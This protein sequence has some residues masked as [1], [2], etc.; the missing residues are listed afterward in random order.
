M[1][2][3]LEPASIATLKGPTL[4]LWDSIYTS[5][6]SEAFRISVFE[7]LMPGLAKRFKLAGIEIPTA[8]KATLIARLCWDRDS[9]HL[10]PH[11]DKISK[12]TT[13]QIYLPRDSQQE[14]IGTSLF[15]ERGG[16]F[17]EVKKFPF[18]PNSGYAFVVQRDGD[19]PSW[20]GCNKLYALQS[21][22]HSLL[23]EFYGG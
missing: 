3:P 5:I 6:A 12:L 20:H 1:I 8:Q 13:I 22:R 17:T 4:D 11:R 15:I 19:T 10:P 23:F 18:K 2:F 16:Q 14:D 7:K 21:D 9:Y